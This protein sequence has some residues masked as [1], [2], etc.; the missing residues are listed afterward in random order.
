[1]S[2]ARSTGNIG[3][4]I[5][6]STTCV[7]VTDGTTDLLIMSGS[8]RVTIPGDLVVLGGIAGSSAESASYSLSSSFATNANLLDG[9]DG[10][11]FLQTGSFNT[12]SESIDTRTSGLAGR[13]TTVEGNYATTGSNIFIGSQIITGSI[14]S[15][16]DIVTTGQI[17]AQTINV[18]QVTSSIVYS[19]GSNVFGT[20]ISNTQEFTGSMLATGSLTMTGPIIGS[21]SVCG[22]MGNFNCIGIGTSTPNTSLH[23]SGTPGLNDPSIRLTDCSVSGNGG[24]V[25]ISADKTGVGYNNL[26]TVAFSHTFRGGGS[27]L[28][29]LTID[30]NGISCFSGTVCTPRLQV[31]NNNSIVVIE[32]TATNGEGTL[33]IAGKNSGGTSRSAIFKYDNADIIRIST[34]DAIPMRFETSD[35]T[36]LTISSTGISTF[37]CQVCSSGIYSSASSRICG[38]LLISDGSGTAIAL[39]NAGSIRACISMTGNEG[40]LSL[41][42]SATAKNVYLSAYYDSYINAG[43]FGLGTN[44]PCS[45]F[46]VVVGA[47]G[48]RRLFINY[49]DSL[50]TIKA[51]S[52]TTSPEALRLIGDG[53]RFNLG[54]TGSGNEALRLVSTGCVACFAGTVCGP[55]YITTQGSSVSYAAGTNYIVW[56]SE[57]EIC[58]LDNNT[59]GTYTTMKT[60][61]ADRTG[62]L[63]LRF[64]GYIISGPTYFAWRVVKNGSSSFVCG[65]YNRCLAPGCSTSVH[66][67][68]TFESNIGPVNPGDCVTLQMVSSDGGGTPVSGQGQYLFAKE[69]RLSS[70]TPNF[71]AGSPNIAFGDRLGIGCLTPAA[72]LTIRSDASSQSA[73]ME[74]A[75]CSANAYRYI[76]INAGGGISYCIPGGTSQSPFIEVQGGESSVGGG[77]FKVRTGAMGSV[78]DRLIITQSGVA[79]FA[80]TVCAPNFFGNITNSNSDSTIRVCSYFHAKYIPENTTQAMFSV[81][82]NGASATY[83]QLVGTNAGVGWSSS[84]IY[85]ASNSGYWGGYVGSGTSVSTTGSGAFITSISSNN[86]GTQTYNVSNANNGTGTSTL[87]WVYVT[88]LTYGGYSTGFTPL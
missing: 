5:K 9:I 37:A 8:G 87:V 70:T 71:S 69:L 11:S 68:T 7:T 44:S 64:A 15:N 34:A 6:T 4:V 80:S 55:Q 48:A 26:T 21:S 29:Y 74:I 52:N 88:T 82:T 43:K 24:N 2:K 46:D 41:Y 33:T 14:C 47:A 32:G 51:A 66:S 83:V 22:V 67:Y 36:R 19:C 53:I 59:G 62:C 20:N 39:Y 86:A 85:H 27:A 40:D 10:A 50:I 61:I 58:S 42:S 18:Q 31:F 3:N 79:C 1:M 13:I 25:Y 28:P 63:T 81:T 57:G 76:S 49:D 78:S 77:S 17:V 23:I 84:Q 16:G 56:N 72:P 35:V 54:T 38:N 73:I 75:T 45:S 12:F 60:W 65:H 30:L